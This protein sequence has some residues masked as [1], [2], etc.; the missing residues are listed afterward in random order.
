MNWYWCLKKKI[1]RGFKKSEHS[2][3]C[4]CLLKPQCNCKFF[5][6]LTQWRQDAC[7]STLGIKWVSSLPKSQGCEPQWSAQHRRYL[8]ICRSKSL[9]QGWWSCEVITSGYIHTNTH[10]PMCMHTQPYP[11]VH[12]LKHAHPHIWLPHPQHRHRMWN[13]H[14]LWIKCFYLP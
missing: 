13:L 14:T 7:R 3:R 10:T 2:S 5:R 12:S 4:G 11:D 8:W 9:L 1:A 6:L